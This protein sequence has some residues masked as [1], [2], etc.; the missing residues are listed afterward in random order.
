MKQ[1]RS[2]K[3]QPEHNKVEQ[4]YLDTEEAA[5]Y[6]C[7]APITLYRKRVD[8]DGPPFSRIGG[9]VIYRRADVDAWVRARLCTSTADYDK[10]PG[11]TAK[12]A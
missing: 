7:L 11:V 10:L 1:S 8:G 6:L 2:A 5:R 4:A 3:F 12:A 9:R